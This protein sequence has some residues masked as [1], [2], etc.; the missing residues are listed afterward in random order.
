MEPIL[1]N[2]GLSAIV[3]EIKRP[4]NR[5]KTVHNL[6]KS[7]VARLVDFCLLKGRHRSF[8][9]FAHPELFSSFVFFLEIQLENGT[10][11]T[12]ARSVD[13]K[14]SV[15]FL[16]STDDIADTS[17]IPAEYWL[18]VGIGITPAK[19]L[20]DG[21]LGF[22]V[23]SPFDYRDLM[24]YVLR[25]QD[26][27]SD[28]FHLR[29]FRGKQRDWKPFLAHLLGLNAD[30]TVSLYEEGDQ[31]V[32]LDLEIERHRADVGNVDDADL[33]RIEGLLAIRIRELEEISNSLDNFDFARPDAE[34]N[35]TLVEQV[36]N[37][38]SQRNE[39]VYRLTQLLWRLDESLAEDSILFN[40]KQTTQLFKEAGISFAGQIKK[41]FEQ[42]VEFNRAISEERQAY[43]LEE[44]R[45]V[46]G[47][48][49]AIQPEIQ[50]LQAERA[51]LFEFLESSSTIAKYKEVSSRAI[52]LKADIA[53][54]IR[55]RDALNN[56][57]RLRQEKR[58]I[59]ER[60]SSL[61]TA[62]ELDVQACIENVD[63][64]YYDIQRYFDEIIYSVL[65]EHA[66]LTVSASSTG[67]LNFTA[68]I[69]DVRGR[70]TSAGRGFTFRKLLCIAFDLA[71]LRSYRNN[72]FPRF[73]FHDG[74]FESLEPRAKRRLVMVLR[75]YANVGLQPIITTLD[76][77][78]PDLAGDS[79][80]SLAAGDVICT[81][82]DEG[83]SGRLFKMATF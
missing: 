54:L 52:E 47:R 59:H 34:A 22:S 72:A 3:A 19:R 6:G 27:Y 13:P 30:L 50:D 71:V 26:D 10:Y 20:L 5:G 33:V 7:T 23:I 35:Q 61:Q 78:I 36:E 48:L 4:E 29:K 79:D 46:A 60:K 24:G 83:N 17:Q 49:Q 38:I 68:D 77:D 64:R 82:S 76:S 51:R 42:L 43:L 25:E 62:L 16:T 45:E 81:L 70:P 8:F 73:A 11:L 28:V 21:L 80:E 66:L 65:G 53:S 56:I 57:V 39:E 44:R 41:S 67:S 55:R 74:V 63:S 32:K 40:T 12:I 31:E 18:H 37:T 14:G 69:V 9:L 15:S 75:D 2:F 1:F 58:Q